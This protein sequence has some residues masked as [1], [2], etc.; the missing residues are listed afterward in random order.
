MLYV[1]VLLFIIVISISIVLWANQYT[2]ALPIISVLGAGISTGTGNMD[3]LSSSDTGNVN[4]INSINSVTGGRVHKKQTEL[5][6]IEKSLDF[7]K[8]I[9]PDNA[10]LIFDGH[11]LIHMLLGAKLSIDDFRN[12]L[13]KISN[14]ISNI[15]NADLHIVIKNPNEHLTEKFNEQYEKENLNLSTKKRKSAAEKIPYFNELTGL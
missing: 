1:V 11:N 12:G 2:N 14:V 5:F 6:D 10:K 7:K 8:V 4:S 15:K 9:L 3:N 13:H